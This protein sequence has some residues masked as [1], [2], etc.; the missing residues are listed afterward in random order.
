MKSFFVFAFILILFTPK[1]ILIPLGTTGI[2]IEDFIAFVLFVIAIADFV[3]RR[4]L[5]TSCVL[6]S[7]IFF[8]S[9]NFVSSIVNI[10]DGRVEALQSFLFTAR[11]VEY[12]S[13]YYL[14]IK[15]YESNFNFSYFFK[16]YIVFLLVIYLLQITGLLN[17]FNEF[18]VSRF[19]GNT[20]GPYELALLTAVI[21]FFFIKNNNKYFACIT[22]AILL[23]TASA[24]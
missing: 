12:L 18:S 3:E 21:F 7:Y 24:P 19:S 22:F 13:F 2:R 14:G 23:L 9:V 1:I 4:S 5:L 15:L 10:L 16:C 17:S 11:L 8:I 6:L 20:N